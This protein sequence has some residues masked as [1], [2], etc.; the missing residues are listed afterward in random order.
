VTDD[1]EATVMVTISRRSGPEIADPVHVIRWLCADGAYMG[2]EYNGFR[3]EVC[4][5]HPDPDECDGACESL[6]DSEVATYVATIMAADVE[7]G[8]A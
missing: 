6:Q 1:I 7:D 5:V 2:G 3:F 8:Q 4:P